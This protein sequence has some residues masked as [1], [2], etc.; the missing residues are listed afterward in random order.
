[1]R[2]PAAYYFGALMK[3]KLRFTV[4]PVLLMT[5]AFLAGCGSRGGPADA[6]AARRDAGVPVVAAEV[7]RK[8]VPLEI[9]VVGNV[10][11]YSTISVRSQVTGQLASTHFQE[12]DYVRKGD[13][14]FTVDPAPF[15]AQ[16]EETAANLARAEA[17]YAQAQA[18]LKRDIAQAR[19]AASQA[20]R[21]AELARSGIVSRDQVEQMQSSADAA[22]ESVKADEA[23]V[24]SSEASVAAVRASMS[25]SKILLGYTSIRSP[26]DGRTGNLALKAGNL[27]N[28]NTAEMVSINQVQPIYVTFSV[29]EAHL[30][31]IKR[32]MTQGKLPVLAS[33]Q[34]EASDRVEEG[35]L[36][37]IDN[38][39]DA[40]TGT[41]KLK[42]VFT[43][44]ERS[45]WPGE[46]VRVTLR[47]ATQHNALVVPQTAVQ[48]GQEG[49]FVYVVKPD[50]T[51][52]LRTIVPGARTGQ[53]IAIEGGLRDGETVVTEGHLRLAPG[54]KVSLKT[55][56]SDG[57][58]G[59][60]PR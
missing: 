60:T 3:M 26:I 4:A 20:A 14:L 37:F 48:T 53:E 44:P 59:R 29:P 13:L 54:M 58:R 1:M 56:G 27:V 46:F 47:L 52:E 17:Q 49:Q 28:A 19:Y 41:I 55:A 33:P 18:T 38:S 6:R 57:D 42:G 24:K 23:A 40:T 34:E 12:G 15:Q 25:N 50:H 32:H 30:A 5:A 22:A 51:V 45:L 39:V 21:Y 8:D 31:A 36:A 10:E 9:Q 2:G 16:L 35:R 7:A 11:A 43:N